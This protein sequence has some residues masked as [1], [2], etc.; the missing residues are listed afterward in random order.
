MFIPLNQICYSEHKL[1]LDHDKILSEVMM[2]KIKD[3]VP[4]SE[5]NY[6]NYG[7]YVI[8]DF[9]RKTDN[10]HQINVSVDILNATL[11]MKRVKKPYISLATI[12]GKIVK[13]IR[14]IEIKVK[15]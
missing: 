14:D 7:A 4:D 3:D 9:E 13:K 15:K 2:A 5:E 10:K 6:S 11:H 12:N 1:S 8:L